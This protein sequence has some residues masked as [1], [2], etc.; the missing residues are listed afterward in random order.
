MTAVKH[1]DDQLR[2]LTVD[3]LAKETGIA[4]WRWYELFRDG[5]G[6]KHIKVGKTIRVPVAAL[7]RWMDQEA[8]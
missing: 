4:R 7:Q 5:K 6:P 3:D 1:E 2:M 8:Q